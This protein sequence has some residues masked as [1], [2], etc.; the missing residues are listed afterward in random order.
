MFS[1]G[2]AVNPFLWAFVYFCEMAESKVFSVPGGNRLFGKGKFSFHLIGEIAFNQVRAAFRQGSH[3]VKVQYP[4]FHV[5][6]GES[7]G[8]G[9]YYRER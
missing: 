9:L 5:R 3:G 2:G 1:E 4:M 6:V 8:V 7:G